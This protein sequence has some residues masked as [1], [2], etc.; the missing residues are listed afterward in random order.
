MTLLIVFR[1]NVLQNTFPMGHIIVRNMHKRSYIENAPLS[2]QC[3]KIVDL[4]CHLTVIFV[5]I[6]PGE[7]VFCEL[8]KIVH[9]S[10]VWQ[11]YIAFT[12]ASYY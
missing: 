3:V 10:H 2:E 1:L 9:N 7:P 4:H 8:Q 11:R 6:M 5:I 12:P